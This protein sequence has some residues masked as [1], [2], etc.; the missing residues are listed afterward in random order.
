MFLMPGREDRRERCLYKV[1]LLVLR[2]CLQN[3]CIFEV[4]T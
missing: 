2:V 1:L 3:Y 4:I